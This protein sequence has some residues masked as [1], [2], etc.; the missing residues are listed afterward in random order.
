M[1]LQQTGN[2]QASLDRQC[3]LQYIFFCLQSYPP[4]VTFYNY[5][6][7]KSIF[8]KDEKYGTLS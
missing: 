1:Y 8:L 7:N 2:Y 5:I 6:I 3:L 4:F